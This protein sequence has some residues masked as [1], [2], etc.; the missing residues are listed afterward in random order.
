[1]K[2]KTSL[3]ATL[4]TALV[5]GVGYA[6]WSF[7]SNSEAST[8]VGVTIAPKTES[9]TVT[10]TESPNFTLAPSLDNL[11]FKATYTQGVGEPLSNM[12]L[13]YTIEFTS[14]LD[15]YITVGALAI[16]EWFHDTQVSVPVSWQA[17]MNPTTP[18][19]WTT[20]NGLQSSMQITIT[21]YATVKTTVNPVG[22]DS[23]S[24]NTSGLIASTDHPGDY[25][26][27]MGTTATLS[28]TGVG[29]VDDSVVWSITPGTGDATI[30][31]TSG[32]I[33]PVATGDVTVTATA[34]YAK[35]AR[36]A[37]ATQNFTLWI[38]AATVMPDLVPA[39]LNASIDRTNIVLP[40]IATISGVSVVNAEGKG[41]SDGI[42]VPQGYE[43][44]SSD[45]E[46]ATV[47]GDTITGVAAGEVDIVVRSTE[48]NEVK[49]VFDV[50]IVNAPAV[51]T[52]IVIPSPVL[53]ID[54]NE[55]VDDAQKA[56]A[57]QIRDQYDVVMALVP[58]VTVTGG[59]TDIE[60][61]SNLFTAIAEGIY[62]VVFS[63][64]GCAN[65]TVTVTVTDTTPA[66]AKAATIVVPALTATIDLNTI[67][68]DGVLPFAVTLKDQ[69][70][71][72]ITGIV[73]SVSEDDDIAEWDANGFLAYAIGEVD[74]T[75]SYA[76]CPDVIVVVT[77]VDT[78]IIAPPSTK[79][80]QNK[81]LTILSGDHALSDWTPALP[82][83]TTDAITNSTHISG[84]GFSGYNFR[85]SGVSPT[86]VYFV[87]GKATHGTIFNTTPLGVNVVSVEVTY[88]SGG[89]ETAHQYY[90]FGNSSNP[91][92]NQVSKSGSIKNDSYI[93]PNPVAYAGTVET[94]IGNPYF[95]L[96]NST[97]S[98]NLQLS[99]IVINYQDWEEPPVVNGVQIIGSSTLEYDKTT[100]LSAEVIDQSGHTISGKSVNWSIVSGPG[101]VNSSGVVS[102]TPSTSAS[103]GLE[104]KVQ[105]ECE[106]FTQIHLI[107]VI[108]VVGRV[109]SSVPFLDVDPRTV[110]TATSYGALTSSTHGGM[111]WDI[112]GWNGSGTTRR[113]GS[114]STPGN[115]TNLAKNLVG[116][117][118]N[119]QY[120][121]LDSSKGAFFQI[122]N[123]STAVHRID[124]EFGAL[125]GPIKGIIIEVSK[126]NMTYSGT[127]LTVT[128]ATD[129]L[130]Y[131]YYTSA[132]ANNTISVVTSDIIGWD[133]AV[134]V[135][136]IA[137]MDNSST[138]NTYIDFNKIKFFNA[139]L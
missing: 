111:N 86:T 109:I 119:P 75:F 58:A 17:G 8:T 122:R 13:S 16:G 33:T 27:A 104:I 69:Y 63:Y 80:L 95:K 121:G 26:L 89:S 115:H 64:V 85:T 67:T 106:D 131:N 34:V 76:D 29:G 136:I 78:T 9:G 54:L 15:T 46:I 66:P 105:A 24:I 14:A 18:T 97:N 25:E 101:D 112:F 123:I 70:D 110:S 135:R 133:A 30:N 38:I 39:T 103:I 68:D 60:W 1:M 107:T 59:S 28:A 45:P 4:A 35:A 127:A 37:K 61:A 52:T 77:V 114:N 65:Q 138:A 73:T 47:S 125:T 118:G 81:T 48:N 92:T 87:A 50:T 83:S 134:S 51:A 139:P 120:P 40:G 71:F 11:T 126:T 22:P 74:I 132:F 7:G 49:K 72:P 116:L 128:S 84:I 98:V 41:P 3:I 55:A 57:V 82:S 137:V 108:D 21:V 53:S 2:L 5:I 117:N 32:L 130:Y 91:V 129:Q 62:E 31:P 10:I 36:R 93:A 88:G 20:M 90:F 6:A 43:V 56:F 96:E 23:L 44:V 94:D 12:D 99:K 124:V 113:F 102:V 19:E 42:M 100:T 79:T